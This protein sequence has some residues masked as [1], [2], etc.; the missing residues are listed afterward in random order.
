MKFGLVLISILFP[1]ATLAQKTIILSNQAQAVPEGKVWVLR[2]DQE[3]LVE[4]A[5]RA[6][7]DGNLCNAQV[8]SRPGIIGAILFGA[9]DQSAT[10]HFILTK[11]LSKVN[12]TNE[13]TYLIKINSFIDLKTFAHL[14]DEFKTKT[15]EEIG[16]KELIIHYGEKVVLPNAGCIT[17]LQIFEFDQ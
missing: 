6:L 13:F 15:A 14:S 17:S 3:T 16:D 4:F 2:A 9:D 5:A 11:G 10:T 7:R 12:Y 8:R 1:L